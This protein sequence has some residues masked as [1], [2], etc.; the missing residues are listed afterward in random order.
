MSKINIVK[1][2]DLYEYKSNTVNTINYEVK[3]NNMFIHGYEQ[4]S[5][6]S[7][8][9]MTNCVQV[10][11]QHGSTTIDVTSRIYSK[12]SNLLK[13]NELFDVILIPTMLIVT[14]VCKDLLLNKSSSI[15]VGVL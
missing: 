1:L 15:I 6:K 13:L 2:Y 9:S 14:V 8:S 12:Q 4:H 10:Y 3:D 11:L 5:G 7:L